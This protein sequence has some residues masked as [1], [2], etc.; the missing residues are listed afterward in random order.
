MAD[1]SPKVKHWFFEFEGPVLEYYGSIGQGI[2]FWS[3][4]NDNFF[5]YYFSPSYEWNIEQ[6]KKKPDVAKSS[7]KSKINLISWLRWEFYC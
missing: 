4:T 6:L 5:F 3:A 1:L 2:W 7:A